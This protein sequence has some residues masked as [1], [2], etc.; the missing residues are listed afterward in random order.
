VLAGK[1]SQRLSS[2]SVQR[3]IF[4]GCSRTYLG[5]EENRR[6]KGGV[7]FIVLLQVQIQIQVPVFLLRSRI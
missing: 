3:P 2:S 1:S 6:K 7:C 4:S 5:R